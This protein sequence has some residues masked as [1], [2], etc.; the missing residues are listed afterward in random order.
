VANGEAIGG[1]L[2]SGA[3]T[4]QE[5][6]LVFVLITQAIL[7]VGMLALA[8]QVGVLFQRIAPMGALVTTGGV[9]VGMEAPRL[10]L[11]ALSGRPIEIGGPDA[12]AT[13]LFF[14]SPSCPVCKTLL[15]VVKRIATEERRMLRVIWASDGDESRQVDFVH[16]SGLP[17]DDYVVSRELG[18]AYRV[19]RLPHAVV[20]ASDGRVAAK[21]LVNNREQVE[22]LIR[23][24]ELG[25]PSVQAYLQEG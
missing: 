16:E 22:S 21:G 15:P 12:R 25:V 23:A 1:D 10:R 7:L 8:R 17:L 19:D 14:V 5:A 20:V 3:M 6:L 24:L 2:R 18:L 4:V 13:L 11:A 9:T